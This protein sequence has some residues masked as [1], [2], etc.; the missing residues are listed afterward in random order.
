MASWLL[1]PWVIAF[2]AAGLAYVLQLFWLTGMFLMMLGA[3]VWPGILVNVGMAL[4][5]IDCWLGKTHRALMVIPLAFFLFG[6]GLCAMSWF[7]A[8]ALARDIADRRAITPVRFNPAKQSLVIASDPRENQMYEGLQRELQSNFLIDTVF[9]QEDIGA[10]AAS[11]VVPKAQCPKDVNFP[12]SGARVGGILTWKGRPDNACF[13]QIPR[14]PEKAQVTVRSAETTE[15]WGMFEAKILE[16]QIKGDGQTARTIIADTRV[17][18][19]IPLFIAGCALDSGAAKW[20]CLH[21]PWTFA[22]RVGGSDGL[23]ANGQTRIRDIAQI[24]GLAARPE[25]LIKRGGY[26]ISPTT[27]I[28]FASTALGLNPSAESE[29]LEQQKLEAFFRDLPALIKEPQRATDARAFTYLPADPEMIA[30]HMGVILGGIESLA[31]EMPALDLRRSLADALIFAPT[32]A[33]E[34]NRAQILRVA[35]DDRIFLK[36]PG[37]VAR[38]GDLG[39]PAGPIL[40]KELARAESGV[41]ARGGLA[42]G[43]LWVQKMGAVIGLCRAGI[44]IDSAAVRA[45]LRDALAQPGDLGESAF[46]A[47]LRI[48]DRKSAEAFTASDARTKS[49][50]ADMLRTVT[51]ASPRS[52]CFPRKENRTERFPRGD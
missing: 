44:A 4:L 31:D 43:D 51:T 28:G 26:L 10:H 25:K 16:T 6:I 35:Q 3:M 33:L 39:A 40:L 47:L 45:A 50:R 38:M 41:Y 52:V 1:R 37:L 7:D 36:S 21:A 19:P 24:L 18:P 14:A 30:R 9:V 11:L 15:K 2:A 8:G 27:E 34:A 13:F 32:S 48:G 12:V 46:V 49:W 42:F 29:R 17:F 23:S 22:R 5:A 20:R